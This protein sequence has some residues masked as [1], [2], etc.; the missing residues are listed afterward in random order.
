MAQG[1]TT[2]F[3]KTLCTVVLFAAAAAAS[4][5]CAQ[6]YPSKPI[7]I[8]S[9]YAPGGSTDVVARLV[10]PKMSA[11]LGQPV[12]VENRAGAAGTIGAE[13]VAHAAPDGYTLL[14]TSSAILSSVVFSS[15]N[16]PYD[17]IKDFTPITAAVTQPGILVV[18]ASFAAASYKE[19]SQYARANPGKL[20]Y[21]T[22]GIGSSFHFMGEIIKHADGINMVHVPY[23]G[24]AQAAQAVASG[25]V[26]VGLLSNSSGMT[27]VRTGKAR[28]I[29]ILGDKRMAE[30][31]DVPAIAES[32]PGVER[33]AD[34]L[35]FY[36]PA[37]MP[38]GLLA[39]VHGEIVKALNAPEVVKALRAAGME[40]FGNTPEE[41]S[42]LMRR[43]IALYRKMV[44][45]A[46]IKLE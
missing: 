37:G 18:N 12:L 23:K 26:Q 31:P 24:G 4:S 33:P 30:L 7:R 1:R 11:A 35:G 29:A 43:D 3:A 22:T 10:A 38:T 14:I 45:I 40:V 28:A 46:G 5:A 20:S 8:I 25:E 19:L 39:R 32:L 9:P 17:P 44:P 6:S 41:F 42:A 15:R 21:A 2:M 27:A 16:A 36:G 13:A 34:W